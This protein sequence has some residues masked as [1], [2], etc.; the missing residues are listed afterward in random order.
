MVTSTSIVILKLIKKINGKRLV[1]T[2]QGKTSGRNVVWE[3]G[4]EIGISIERVRLVTSKGTSVINYESISDG[5]K[6]DGSGKK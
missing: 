4:R 1:N 3:S 2:R 6:S 5:N